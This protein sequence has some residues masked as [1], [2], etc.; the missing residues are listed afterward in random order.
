MDKP[1][2][3]VLEENYATWLASAVNEKMKEGY[4]LYGSPFSRENQFCQ[5][6]ILP[7]KES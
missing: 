5:A 4:V 7:T 1:F 6:M 2:Y 3:I